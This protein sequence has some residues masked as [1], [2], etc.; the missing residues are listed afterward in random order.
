MKT[1]LNSAQNCSIMPNW[2][3]RGVFEVEGSRLR[4]KFQSGQIM[5]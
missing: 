4:L 1:D 3:S 2:M 5:R